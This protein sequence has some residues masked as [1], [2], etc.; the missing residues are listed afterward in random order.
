MDFEIEGGTV[1]PKQEARPTAHSAIQIEARLKPPVAAS[2]LPFSHWRLLRIVARLG[3]YTGVI[4]Y[5]GG[6]YYVDKFDEKLEVASSLTEDPAQ[7]PTD[8]PPFIFQYGG[9]SYDIIPVANYE[10]SGLIVTHN[11][12]SSLMDAYHTS[13]SVDFRDICLVWGENVASQIFRKYKF[14]SMPWSCHYQSIKREDAY[15]LVDSQLSNNHLLAANE[16]VRQTIR[17]MQIGDQ[18]RLQGMLI[19]YHPSGQPHMLRRSSTVRDDEGNG[20]CEVLWVE[21]AT[22][23]RKGQTSWHIF[24]DSGT[25]LLITSVILNLALFLFT[26][27]GHYKRFRW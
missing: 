13:D 12:V 15:S 14:W 27:L 6:A 17:A 2:S 26:P 11:D 21:T 25:W 5:L 18:V 4:L 9:Q 16:K 7:T 3:L 22:I 10:I 23:I 19:N 20:A 1:G 8:E 24:K